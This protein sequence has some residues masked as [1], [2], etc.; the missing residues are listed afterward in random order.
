MATPKYQTPID[1][2]RWLKQQMDKES[3]AGPVAGY[4]PE[5]YD[6][7]W[8]RE[9][10]IDPKVT[11]WKPNAI[12]DSLAPY[13]VYD[14]DRERQ[15]YWED[16]RNVGAWHDYLQLQGEGFE[17]PEPVDRHYIETAY[18]Y[19]K[20]QN[21]SPNWNTWKPLPFGH[22]LSYVAQQIPSPESAIDERF[23]NSTADGSRY[24]PGT[25][26][27]NP[28]YAVQALLDYQNVITQ[29]QD[30]AQ[31]KTA[32]QSDELN[33]FYITTQQQN[34]PIYDQYQKELEESAGADYL[35]LEPWEKWILP[36]VSAADMK[37]RPNWS[38]N[39]GIVSQGL[40]AALGGFGQ[41]ALV[42][43]VTGSVVPGLGTAAGAT[44]GGIA[45]AVLGFAGSIDAS[46]RARKGEEVPNWLVNTNKFFNFFAAATERVI[47]V[48][49]L[50]R[51]E[52][53]P[54]EWG[55]QYGLD[56]T[57]KAT[58]WGSQ[59]GLPTESTPPD[60]IPIASWEQTKAAIKAADLQYESLAGTENGGIGDW[61]VDSISWLANKID[62][63]KNSGLQTGLGEVWQLHKG[64]S[65]P[66]ALKG[67]GTIG[68][69]S[70]EELYNMLLDKDSP[71]DPEVALAIFR[72]K[73][74]FSGNLND[75]I[76]QTLLDPS[77]VMPRVFANMGVDYAG[78]KIQDIQRQISIEGPSP[79]LIDNLTD[80]MRMQASFQR[81]IGNP[82]VD[83]SPYPVQMLFDY[84]I[85]RKN[86]NL[87]STAPFFRTV[88]EYKMLKDTGLLAPA[89]SAFEFKAGDTDLGMVYFG[90][91]N[92][93][94]WKKPDGSVEYMYA[95][96]ANAAGFKF[97]IEEGK[98]VLY[99]NGQRAS[100]IGGED[101][102][103]P[104]EG[105]TVIDV[106][107][108]AP[109]PAA[110]VDFVEQTTTVTADVEL[111]DGTRAES[112]DIDPANQTFE[113][114]GQDG[115]TYIAR[116]EDNV[117]IDTLNSEG[118]SIHDPNRVITIN[119]VQVRV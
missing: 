113:A 108:N 16:P 33:Q 79:A 78:T 2:Y 6:K 10:T 67:S 5:G 72:D 63:E 58:E 82:I 81:S 31:L 27:R 96:A 104:P 29:I 28:A 93:I 26:I 32:Q 61:L 50:Q 100:T 48:S 47:G 3:Y 111:P 107:P 18:Q 92:S 71:V 76:Y 74:G 1:K 86:Q 59:Y 88:A 109:R 83:I 43:G 110:D 80:A 89:A 105:T 116:V 66:R 85:G 40:M 4:R 36:L 57:A 62:P 38:T 9:S 70:Q 46:L 112:V 25:D 30:E 42:G 55:S 98:P 7:V 77:V 20:E 91:D 17:A 41:G 84:V 68:R 90:T 15:S 65:G 60:G 87:R 99:V 114:H 54:V 53:Q 39:I 8:H 21:G 37:N 35:E 103:T 102:Y 64:L 75:M 56:P 34:N 11:Y 97:V 52:Q 118:V 24:L 117:V 94:T 14:S 101:I 51:Q 23:L 69:E 19:M 95:N 12:K 106:D 119:P 44:G 13:A 115:I 49:E 45:G 73:Y 22:M